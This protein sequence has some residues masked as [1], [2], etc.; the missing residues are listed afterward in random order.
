MLFL[1][2]ELT[3]GGW[4]GNI[5]V[6]STGRLREA[7]ISVLLKSW[8]S[9]GVLKQYSND[10]VVL[11]RKSPLKKRCPEMGPKSLGSFGWCVHFNVSLI[12]YG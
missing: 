1:R 2:A 11:K 8:P 3:M 4:M 9:P 10:L 6:I 7:E 5:L 12:F